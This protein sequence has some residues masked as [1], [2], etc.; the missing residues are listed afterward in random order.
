M[1]NTPI[2]K[3]KLSVFKCPLFTETADKYFDKVP[4]VH[5]AYLDFL[6]VKRENPIAPFG[7][8]DKSN[9][10]STPLAD[11]IPK[12]RHAHL[13]H[14][15]SVFY[16]VSGANPVQ[17]KLYSIMSHDEAGIGQ[18]VN[19]KKQKSLGKK[20]ANQVFTSPETQRI[21]ED[22]ISLA[23]RLNEE[24]ILPD[25]LLE[26]LNLMYNQGSTTTKE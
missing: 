21:M 4:S 20:M 23:T 12:L 11:S 15:I 7:K 22:M 13:S 25:Y 3:P 8:S 14:D 17:L 10:I 6:K 19:Y 18:P 16:T 1:K 24:K 9:P 2:E 26:Q 5:R